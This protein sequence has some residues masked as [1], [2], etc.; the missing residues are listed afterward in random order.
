MN[1]EKSLANVIFD[2]NTSEQFYGYFLAELNKSFSND[3]PTAC[4]AKFPNS[5]NVELIIGK[6][7]WEE[8][9]DD[10]IRKS[11]VTHELLHVLFNHFFFN[12]FLTDKTLLNL[13]ADCSINQ[14]INSKLWKVPEPILPSLFPELNL[15]LMEGTEY[16]YNK[17]KEAKDKKEQSGNKGED[18]KG[19]GEKPGNGKGTSG[20]GNFDTFIDSNYEDWHKSWDEITKNMSEGEKELLKK[21]IASS[22]REAVK[23]TEK[24]R[25]TLPAH[26]KNLIEDTIQIKKPVVSW[27]DLFKQFVGSCMSSDPFR[28]RKR[29][30]FRFDDA[31]ANRTKQKIRLACCIDESGSVGQDELN[32]F[33]NEIHHMYK[34]G[35]KI[36]ILHWDTE[37]H[38]VT[39]YKGE[40]VSI[41]HCAGG[42]QAS[43]A[44]DYVNTHRKDYD[45]SVVLTDGY[46]E[47]E[48][49]PSLLPL[50][51][52]I[53]SNGSDSF[54][55]KSKKL[56]IN[57]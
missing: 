18:S 53:S 57:G 13:A 30:N 31:P 47:H 17:F 7:F 34:N 6:K 51:W 38:A 36:D 19:E 1:Y 40:K 21:Q 12:S 37:V 27:K 10:E 26:L 49:S 2:L 9:D 39:Q 24:S 48:P 11:I 29:P 44:I 15:N 8:V 43:S 50:L 25:G 32:Q 42:T 55:H 3:F 56:K 23:E 33:Y 14:M 46:I 35:V 22:V 28:T 45:L 54:S 4:V 41:R 16:Y 5:A 20:C 52:V